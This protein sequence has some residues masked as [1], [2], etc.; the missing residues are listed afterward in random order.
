MTDEMRAKFEAHFSQPP[1]EWEFVRLSATSAWPDMYSP[2]YMQC[3]WEGW[4][5]AHVSRDA[6]V[7]AL[8]DALFQIS[9]RLKTE[10]ESD[11]DDMSWHTDMIARAQ[12]LAN[13]CQRIES[14]PVAIM[15]TRD[16]LGICAPTEEDFPALYALQ[17]KRVRLVVEDGE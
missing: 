3:A 14:A 16:A 10:R 13:Q 8:Q 17:G 4:Q 7:E 1:Y 9:V 11:M 6:E 15:D 5:A 2:Y 12:Y